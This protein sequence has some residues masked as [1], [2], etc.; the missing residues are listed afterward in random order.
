MHV[1]KKWEKMATK[2]TDVTVVKEQLSTDFSQEV[3]ICF[4]F[5]QPG[6][7]AKGKQMKPKTFH[8]YSSRKEILL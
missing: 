7:G 8:P 6:H 3:D 4:G 1:V 2:F 5:I